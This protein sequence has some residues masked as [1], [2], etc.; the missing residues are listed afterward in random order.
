MKHS[1]GENTCCEAI[2]LYNDVCE[3]EIGGEGGSR[4]YLYGY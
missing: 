1:Y 4:I 2:Q 3:C